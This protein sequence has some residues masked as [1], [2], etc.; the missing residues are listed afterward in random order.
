MIKVKPPS[1][2]YSNRKIQ[3]SKTY[4]WLKV[5]INKSQGNTTHPEHSYTSIANPDYSKTT[6]AQANIK[7]TGDFKEKLIKPLK[8][9]KKIQLNYYY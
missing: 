5:T 2:C 6:E 1:N 4:R 9:Y 8:K 3:G 7:V